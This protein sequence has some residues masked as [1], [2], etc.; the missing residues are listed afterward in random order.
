MPELTIA[1]VRLSSPSV[2]HASVNATPWLLLTD[3]FSIV[4]VAA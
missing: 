2:V 4:G 1:P 3:T